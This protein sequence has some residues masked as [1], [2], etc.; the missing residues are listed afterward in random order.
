MEEDD[1]LGEE[2]RIENEKHLQ[3]DDSGI[4]R[5]EGGANLDITD[6]SGSGSGKVV[7]STVDSEEKT[8][9]KGASFSSD[10]VSAQSQSWAWISKVP[11]SRL[12]AKWIKSKTIRPISLN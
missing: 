10:H 12:W 7:D 9:T 8:P 6:G 2:L 5:A 4:V 3:I 11:L 1:L